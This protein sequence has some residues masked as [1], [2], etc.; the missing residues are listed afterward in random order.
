MPQR[1]MLFSPRPET[2]NSEYPSLD[3]VLEPI[4]KLEH[5]IEL[6]VIADGRASPLTS[7]PTGLS[8]APEFTLDVSASALDDPTTIVKFLHHSATR[9]SRFSME[10]RLK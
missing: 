10:K 9:P 3:L 4:H 8:L 5:L 7:S 1:L 2:D 6:A